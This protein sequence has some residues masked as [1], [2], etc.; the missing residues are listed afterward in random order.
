[1]SVSRRKFLVQSSAAL[2]LAPW[3]TRW[4]QAPAPPPAAA[5][6]D[7]RRNVGIFTARGGTIGWLSSKDALVV[8]DTQYP[9][10]AK[11]CLDGL[12]NKS[13]RPIDLVFNTHHHADHT[14]GNGVFKDA[15]KRIVAQANVPDLQRKSPPP[16]SGPAAGAPVVVADV[17]FAKSWSEQIGDERVTATH[18]GPGHTGGD[19]IFIFAQANV[20]HMGDL[21]FH[22]MH[23]F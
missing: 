20:V 17:T 22:Q 12:K 8:V 19:A 4:T 2:A 1:M 21:L 7:V 14:A 15:A 3:L 5:F 18:Y 16:Q 9:D 11:T 13:P 23:P 6:T 10:T